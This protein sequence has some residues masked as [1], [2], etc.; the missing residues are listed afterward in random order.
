MLSVTWCEAERLLPAV[1]KI[2]C[3][4]GHAVVQFYYES[5]KL[6]RRWAVSP[7]NIPRQNCETQLAAEC[8]MEWRKGALG[9]SSRMCLGKVSKQQNK[10][11]W[12]RLGREG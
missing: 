1:E 2:K 5:D 6:R 7:D 4:G 12:G 9:C 10:N 8:S 11:A 3:G